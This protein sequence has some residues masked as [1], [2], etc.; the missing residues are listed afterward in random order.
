[1]WSDLTGLEL[2]ARHG[3][4]VGTLVLA[5]VAAAIIAASVTYVIVEHHHT[6]SA[7]TTGASCGQYKDDLILALANPLPSESATGSASDLHP[8]DLV[9]IAKPH[10]NEITN[11][12]VTL[13]VRQYSNPGLQYGEWEDFAANTQA[14]VGDS[15]AAQR[16]SELEVTEELPGLCDREHT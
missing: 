6:A 4:G 1:M 12:L 14:Q 13:N 5:V 7:S 3:I 2:P 8:S 16:C 9:E 10:Q 11:E 15:Y